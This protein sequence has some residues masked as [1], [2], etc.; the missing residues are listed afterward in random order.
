MT[1]LELAAPCCLTLAA[2]RVDGRPALLGI[3]LRHPPVQLEARA[4]A[5]LGVTGAR[6]DAAYAHA[7]AFQR[8]QGLATAAEIE[9]ELAVPSHMGLGSSAIAGL[10][11]ARALAALHGLPAADGPELARAAGVAPDD[12]LAVH[13]FAGGGLLAVGEDGALLRRAAISHGD[14]ARD[15]VFV[16]VLPRVPP[17]TPDALEDTLRRE[18]W[19]A[20]GG[21]GVEAEQ[22]FAA[23]L[24][25]AAAGDDIGAFAAAL[26]K[27]QALAPGAPLADDEAAILAV[28][29][30]AGA[31]VCGRA[32]TGLALYA[33]LEGADP[34]REL[35]RA[36]AVHLGHTSGTVMAT[37]CDTTGARHRIL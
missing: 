13:A 23:E 21:L 14:V 24:W 4:A 28:M 29:G 8:A 33:L 22:L 30:E 31:L 1:R 16:I 26:T 18:L 15:W 3:T 12:G 27:L 5:Q 36:L 7:A 2:A 17:G 34:S 11:A 37:I 19:A 9:L 25:P 10:A 6:A 35:R 32:P 20:A